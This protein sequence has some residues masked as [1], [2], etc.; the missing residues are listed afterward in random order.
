MEDLDDPADFSPT[1]GAGLWLFTAGNPGSH[2]GVWYQRFCRDLWDHCQGEL[3]VDI[4]SL[5][6]CGFYPQ[7]C[8]EHI[9]YS[10]SWGL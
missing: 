4:V 1:S 10:I 8:V 2:E 3:C 9:L 6:S 7:F 5:S